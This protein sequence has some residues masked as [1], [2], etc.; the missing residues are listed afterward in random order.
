MDT[1]E[2]SLRKLRI[3]KWTLPVFG[4]GLS[5]ISLIWVLSKFPF[6]QLGQHLRT[7]DW[8]WVAV[9]VIAEVLVY[10]ADAWRWMVL[11]RPAG[12]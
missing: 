7:M 8:R 4:Y 10:F 11:L 2:A 9:A 6:A 1:V 12:A 5:A 3:P